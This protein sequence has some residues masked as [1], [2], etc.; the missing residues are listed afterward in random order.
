MA[1]YQKLNRNKQEALSQKGKTFSN[2]LDFGSLTQ[3]GS[4]RY[5]KESKGGKIEHVDDK[6]S[7]GRNKKMKLVQST[8][9]LSRDVGP[10]RVG[11][12]R[13][14]TGYVEFGYDPKTKNIVLAFAERHGRN[15]STKK[16]IERNTTKRSTVHASEKFRTND[17][18]F[19]GGATSI[20]SNINHDQV[21]LQ[22][23]MDKFSDSEQNA[24]TL[25]DVM[26]FHET[27]KSKKNN[28]IPT[29]EKNTKEQKNLVFKQKF[30]KAINEVKTEAQHFKSKPRDD[31]IFL[32]MLKKRLIKEGF[33]ETSDID[34]I[35]ENLEKQVEE[36]NEELKEKGTE[37]IEESSNQ[38]M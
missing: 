30:I 14:N 27:S 38:E 18:S 29:Q 6:S 32:Y 21:F 10:T 1:S 22:Q 7:V 24:T 11:E 34:E 3:K 4:P 2:G 12:I 15:Q 35:I 31:I 37:N 5:V 16:V 36:E 25:D 23:Q 13:M 17:K 28:P 9:S 26:T 33:L 20:R 8:S 19:L